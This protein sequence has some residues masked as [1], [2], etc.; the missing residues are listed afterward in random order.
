MGHPFTFW[1]ATDGRRVLTSRFSRS[2]ADLFAA[3]WNA[4]C[5]D[6]DLPATVEP[7]DG[8][9]EAWDDGGGLV[10]FRAF[11]PRDG[12]EVAVHLYVRASA[13]LKIADGDDE[14][15]ESLQAGLRLGH[16]ASNAQTVV[17]FRQGKARHSLPTGVPASEVAA[18]V[19]A[20]K[21]SRGG[22]PWRSERGD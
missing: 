1:V 16:V 5:G 15:A 21:A 13:V 10:G 20:A 8:E 4:S 14:E 18:A 7:V 19:R 2:A 17:V 12:R 3:D 22:R 11:G 9:S 6:G